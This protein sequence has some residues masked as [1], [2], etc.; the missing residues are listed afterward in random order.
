VAA[1]LRGD[2]LVAYDDVPYTSD[3]DIYGQ[4]WGNRVY[5][6]LVQRTH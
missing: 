6:P 4:M 5:V 2:F 1:G 3:R